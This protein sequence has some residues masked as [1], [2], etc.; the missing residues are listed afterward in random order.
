MLPPPGLAVDFSPRTSTKVI[1]YYPLLRT[2]STPALTASF[3]PVIFDDRRLRV[4][5]LFFFLFLYFFFDDALRWFLRIGRFRTG[6]VYADRWPGSGAHEGENV[7]GPTRAPRLGPILFRPVFSGSFF[8]F[9]ERGFLSSFP[10][11]SSPRKKKKRHDACFAPASNWAGPDFAPASR[12]S[13]IEFS[14][15]FGHPL[16]LI[17]RARPKPATGSLAKHSRGT[18]LCSVSRRDRR[19]PTI[20]PN[21]KKSPGPVSNPAPPLPSSSIRSED[22]R[23]ISL[24]TRKNTRGINRGGSLIGGVSQGPPAPRWFPV[25]LGSFDAR[26]FFCC[27]STPSS[28]WRN[29]RSRWLLGPQ[30]VAE[31]KNTTTVFRRASKAGKAREH[32]PAGGLTTCFAPKVCPLFARNL[33]GVAEVS[34]PTMRRGQPVQ[35]RHPWVKF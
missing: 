1:Q 9:A 21:H 4:W 2:T 8:F 33:Y 35:A 15:R 14:R 5:F 30:G 6:K 18:A 27:W 13:R 7:R 28:Q 16:V 20:H 17:V 29:I 32:R 31:H 25:F 12:V 26:G 24:E 34:G 23:K 22:V 11:P 19:V 10:P 3:W